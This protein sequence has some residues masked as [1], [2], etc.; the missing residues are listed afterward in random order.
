MDFATIWLLT[1]IMAV[2]GGFD[3][4]TARLYN[5]IDACE[6]DLKPGLECL[7]WSRTNRTLIDTT[8]RKRCITC[9]PWEADPRKGD[10]MND[11]K[12]LR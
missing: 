4:P 10:A 8:G 6:A 3:I 12:R 5:T 9:E 1:G 7:P 2:P 11:G